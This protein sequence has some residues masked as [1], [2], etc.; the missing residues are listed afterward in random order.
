MA[1]SYKDLINFEGS[2]APLVRGRVQEG[3]GEGGGDR[4][5]GWLE[6]T[7][8]RRWLLLTHCVTA[9]MESLS[10]VA[11][12]ATKARLSWPAPLLPVL[13][14]LYPS[15]R[16]IST[17]AQAAMPRREHICL[18][19]LTDIKSKAHGTSYNYIMNQSCKKK[20]KQKVKYLPCWWN[21]A[22]WCGKFGKC[23]LS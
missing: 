21:Q 20:K 7:A 15:G 19:F 17:S 16:W 10:W 8:G 23:V 6:F 11:V 1:A 3:E 4:P 12:W 2:S 22:F 9:K 13:T 14:S 18:H 5:L